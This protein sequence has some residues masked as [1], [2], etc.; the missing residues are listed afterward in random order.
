MQN[1]FMHTL[2]ISFHASDSRQFQIANLA[3]TEHKN[4]IFFKNIRAI[5]IGVNLSISKMEMSNLKAWSI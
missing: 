5:V 4:Y 3:S 1:S 2:N